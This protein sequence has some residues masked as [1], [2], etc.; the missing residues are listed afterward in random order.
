M[1][2]LKNEGYIYSDRVSSN[3][4]HGFGTKKLS[5]LENYLVVRPKQVHGTE[6]AIITEKSE[7]EYSADGLITTN[8]DLMLTVVTADC[9]PIIFVDEKAGIIG[10]SHQGWKGTLNRL[11]GKMIDKMLSIGATIRNIYCLFGP[12]INDCCYEIYGER[13]QK[14]EDEFKSESI[15][16]KSNGKYFLNMNKA[17]Y[18]T[19]VQKGINPNRIDFFPF[20]TSCDSKRFYSYHRDKKIVGEMVSFVKMK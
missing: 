7:K 1:L 18:L 11:P 6:V 12:A 3:I 15:F 16:R 20:C 17:N 19:V 14:F 9:V 13:L 5:N 8:K 4:I 2:V 10:I